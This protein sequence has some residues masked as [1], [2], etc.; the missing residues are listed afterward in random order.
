MF[1]PPEM[2]A[3]ALSNLDAAVARFA[4]PVRGRRF[5]VAPT[6]RVLYFDIDGTLLNYD[7]SPKAALV[8]G[9]LEFRLKHLS[10][11]KLV[12]VSGWAAIVKEPLTGIPVE[13][14]ARAILQLLDRIFLD[15][16]WFLERLVLADDPDHRCRSIDRTLDWYYA[17]D[18][19]KEFFE[20]AWGAEAYAKAAGD[21]ILMVDPHADGSDLLAW[22]DQ[23]AA[24]RSHPQE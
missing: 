13:H 20:D 21:R 2:A 6:P 18:W 10:F 5:V 1:L 17:D 4:Y 19:A 7:D 14:Q 15:V 12:C 9:A 22:L 16:E 11:S 23:A 24:R 8:G 3:T